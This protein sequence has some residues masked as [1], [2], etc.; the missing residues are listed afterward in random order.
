MQRRTRARL[1]ESDHGIVVTGL[2]PFRLQTNI[3]CLDLN[4]SHG[5]LLSKAGDGGPGAMA[6]H[7]SLLIAFDEETDAVILADINPKSYLRCAI[8]SGRALLARV[9]TL[10]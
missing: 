3:I 6:C 10:I 5:R 4:A 9:R 2:H 7:F 8:R 1:R